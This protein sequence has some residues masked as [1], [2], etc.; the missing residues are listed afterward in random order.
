MMMGTN[1]KALLALDPG[2]KAG[3]KCA[4]LTNEGKTLSL[5][6]VKFVGGASERDEVSDSLLHF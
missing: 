5:D 4:I 3:I 2:F 1:K 6:T